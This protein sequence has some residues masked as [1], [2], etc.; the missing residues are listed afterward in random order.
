MRN[1]LEAGHISVAVSGVCE[2]LTPF[3]HCN[4]LSPCT[5]VTWSGEL[6]M[7]ESNVLGGRVAAK[8]LEGRKL[9]P[10]WVSPAGTRP[11]RVSSSVNEDR[12]DP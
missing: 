10:V 11:W 8:G 7:E 3:V 1:K 4:S 12:N 2:R 9:G 5:P 6:V